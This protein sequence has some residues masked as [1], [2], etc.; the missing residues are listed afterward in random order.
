MLVLKSL[1]LKKVINKEKGNSFTPSSWQNL[2]LLEPNSENEKKKCFWWNLNFTLK[3]F[4]MQISL[5]KMRL[6]LFYLAYLVHN[7]S[8]SLLLF[9]LQNTPIHTSEINRFLWCSQRIRVFRHFQSISK[10]LEHLLT[11]SMNISKVHQRLSDV[12]APGVCHQYRW[13]SSYSTST[14]GAI[15]RRHL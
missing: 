8:K 9:S 10:E 14:I 4:K 2:G 11:Q 5:E 12:Y 13:V 6:L 1:I 7:E 15:N 3:D